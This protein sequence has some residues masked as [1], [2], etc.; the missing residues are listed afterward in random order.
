MHALPVLLSDADIA[1]ALDMD[2]TISSQRHAF[3]ALGAGV[4]SL[5]EKATLPNPLNDSV[6]LCYLSRLSSTSDVVCKLVD[7]HPHNAERG[8]PS[9]HGTVLVLDGKSGRLSAILDAR[10]LTVVRT[11]AGSAVAAD[12]LAPPDVD[13]LA[14]LGCGPQG[15]AHV[16]AMARVRPLRRVRIWSPTPDR[17]R[18]AAAE[19]AAELDLDVTAVDSSEKAVR[20]APV[21][22]TCTLSRTPVVATD[23][24]A[25]GATVISVGSYDAHRTEVPPDLMR[26]ARIVVDDLDTALVHAGPVVQA[27][28]AGDLTRADVVSLGQVLAG[29]APGRTDATQLVFY[30]SVGIG[31]QDA[32]AAEAVLAK[33]GRQVVVAD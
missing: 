25:E 7:V 2:T 24:L 21:V 22:V 23:D 11:A 17:R 12:V 6:T 27:I 3:L 30:N 32:A 1:A 10:T 16:R 31:V 29:T 5:A 18:R 9:V 33:L 26:V 28:S 19:L 20:T 15:R 4:A 14:V 13:E 8:I